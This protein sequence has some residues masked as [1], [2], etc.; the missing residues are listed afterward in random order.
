MSCGKRALPGDMMACLTPFK[1]EI[2]FLPLLL[3]ARFVSKSIQFPQI[4]SRA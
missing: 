4:Q 3:T 2:A 1:E